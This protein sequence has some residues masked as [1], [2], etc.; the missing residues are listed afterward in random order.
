M[1]YVPHD[2]LDLNLDDNQKIQKYFDLYKFFSFLE[3]RTL[4]FSNFDKF[5]DHFEGKIPEAT[6][7]D[8]KNQAINKEQLKNVEHNIKF[9][10]DFNEN[11]TYVNCWNIFNYEL[12]TLWNKYADNRYTICIQSSIGKLKE[13]IANTD[14]SISIGEIKYGDFNKFVLKRMNTIYI[15]SR[16]SIEYQDEHEL[17]LFVSKPFLNQDNDVEIDIDILI[18]RIILSPY[19]NN[20]ERNTL[21]NVINKFGYK[22]LVFDSVI[23]K[24]EQ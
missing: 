20:W 23:L 6:K 24:N 16:K 12:D 7:M 5:E 3:K 19:L 8:W 1:P 14:F 2:L 22:N 18:E 10:E 4:H 11:I 13:S 9:L 15:A 17:R 21:R